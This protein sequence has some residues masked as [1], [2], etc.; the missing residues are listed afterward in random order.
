MPSPH[1]G[2]PA[3]DRLTGRRDKA[4]LQKIDEAVHDYYLSVNFDARFAILVGT[5]K[6]CE[7]ECTASV[8]ALIWMYLGIFYGSAFQN[9]EDARCAFEVAIAWDPNVLLDAESS[10]AKTKAAFAAAWRS[11]CAE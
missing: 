4:A 2:G 8:Q 1:C 9:L 6:A 3:R 10:T 5:S 11:R 7:T